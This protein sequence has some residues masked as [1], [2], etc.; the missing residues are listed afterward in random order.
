MT[1]KLNEM[2]SG[3]QGLELGYTVVLLAILVGLYHARA[4]WNAY[5]LSPLVAGVMTVFSA[6]VVAITSPLLRLFGIGDR[7]ILQLLYGFSVVVA[8][9]YVAGRV[10][11]ARQGGAGPEH[12]RGAWVN[13]ARPDSTQ[14]AGRAPGRRSGANSAGIT[15]AGVPIPLEDETKHFKIIGT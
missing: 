10:L 8:M 3:L 6:I 13:L 15:V 11:A 12:R 9:S 14:Q 1:D 7:N 4:S 5:L 2:T